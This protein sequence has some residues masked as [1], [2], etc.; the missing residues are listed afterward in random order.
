VSDGGNQMNIGLLETRLGF[1]M[2][3]LQTLLGMRIVQAFARYGLSPGAFTTMA[4]I[5]VNPGCSQIA[6]ARE[7]GLDK[8]AMVALLD[9]LEKAGLARRDRSSED[10]RRNL[11]ALTAEGER[12]LAE[13]HGLALATERPIRDALS[14]EELKTLFALTERAYQAIVADD[15]RMAR[16]VV[17]RD[18]GE[19]DMTNRVPAAGP[20]R[21]GRRSRL[22]AS[23][24]S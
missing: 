19:G 21:R 15:M 14:G 10:R 1:R 23:A 16:A 5:S 24:I 12:V 13:M 2:R 22:H 11:I 20:R 18:A 4:L 8:S 3:V 17:D 7:V 9:E 6:L